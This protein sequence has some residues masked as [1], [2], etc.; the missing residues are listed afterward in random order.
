[1][2]L[3]LPTYLVIYCWLGIR[4]NEHSQEN[5]DLK[6]PVEISIKKSEQIP[7]IN[8]I[9]R[10]TTNNESFHF[11]PTDHEN[12][13]KEIFNVDN[14]KME[15]LKTFLLTTSRIYQMCVVLF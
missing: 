14:K 15:L 2:N 11:S 1:M 13:L 9:N 6:H 7:N 5:Y 10:N 3:K 4:P 12:I 8:L